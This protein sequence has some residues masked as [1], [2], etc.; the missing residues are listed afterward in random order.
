MKN[1]F[2]AVLISF[3]WVY[4]ASDH[5]LYDNVQASFYGINLYPFFA[6]TLGLVFSLMLYERFFKRKTLFFDFIFYFCFYCLLLI[7]AEALFYHVFGVVN[8]AALNY[9]GL[10]ICNCLHAVWW[11]KVVYFSMGPIYFFSVRSFEKIS[12][13]KPLQKEEVLKSRF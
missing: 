7:L 12:T 2:W 6:W 9:S 11:M 4:L 1:I 5:Y 8:L 3:V 13:K 10:P